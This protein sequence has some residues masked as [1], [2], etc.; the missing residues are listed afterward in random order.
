MALPIPPMGVAIAAAVT[1]ATATQINIDSGAIAIVP[2]G[3]GI[4]ITC[5]GHIAGFQSW[6]NKLTWD[7]MMANG[8]AKAGYKFTA[9]TTCW[10]GDAL[11]GEDYYP[12][13]W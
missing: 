5:D 1:A 3:G 2:K 9:N 13:G 8:A 11:A 12:G 4:T 7:Y 10:G 6:N